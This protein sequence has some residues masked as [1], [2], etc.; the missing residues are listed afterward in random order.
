M[1]ILINVNYDYITIL[2]YPNPFLDLA[3]Y[4][5]NHFR[6]QTQTDYVRNRNPNKHIQ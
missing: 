6:Y 3:H 4:P 5:E 2:F 1:S